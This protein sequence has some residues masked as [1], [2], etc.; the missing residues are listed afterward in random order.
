TPCGA[1]TIYKWLDAEG[2]LHLSSE[3][4]PA[5][6]QYEKLSVASAP[7]QSGS[8]NQAARSA[9]SGASPARAASRS[10]VLANLRVR[11]CVI[12]LEALERL[13]SGAEP[14]S[15]SELNRLQQTVGR[16]CS[17]DPT[18]RREEEEMAARLRMANGPDCAEARQRLARMMQQ[19]ADVEREQLRSQQQFV[20]DSCTPPVR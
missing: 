6:V 7:S 15:S 19:G 8:R 11:E 1:A 20:S 13:T 4:P 16:N 17:S 10:E 14:T 3:K 9:P 12:A 2:T 18:R 5:G